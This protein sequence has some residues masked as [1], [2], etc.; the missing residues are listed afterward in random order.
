M[1]TCNTNISCYEKELHKQAARMKNYELWSQLLFCC[2]ASHEYH[3]INA[4]STPLSLLVTHFLM[5]A[6]SGESESKANRRIQHKCVVAK[7][8]HKNAQIRKKRAVSYT[9]SVRNSSKHIVLFTI[10]SHS[11]HSRLPWRQS[12][13]LPPANDLF[14]KPAIV[15]FFPKKDQCCFHALACRGTHIK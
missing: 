7:Y 14:Q 11:S 5:P 8:A 15:K 12:E 13:A 6:A 3:Y 9:L 10:F 1:K 2:I 4:Q